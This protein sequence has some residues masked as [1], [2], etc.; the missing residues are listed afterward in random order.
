MYNDNRLLEL[1][2]RQGLLTAKQRSLVEL[3]KRQVRQ[4]LLRRREQRKGGQGKEGAD[5]SQGA[6]DLID[7]ILALRLEHAQTGRPLTEEDLFQAIARESGLPF[8]KL[9]PLDLDIEVVTKT[10]PRSFA[11]RHLILPFKVADGVLSVA[12]CDPD[13]R[14]VLEEVERASQRPI[15]PHITS[16][17]DIRKLLGE[18]HGF[19]SSISAAESHLGGPAVDIAN[20]EQYVRIAS[21]DE[22]AMSDRHIQRAVD[23]LFAY[24]FEQRAS[25]IHLEPKREHC[26]VRLRID[27][28]LHTVYSLPKVVH[29]AIVSRIKAMSRLNIAEK[30]RPQDGRIK[31]DRDGKQSEIRVST[32]PV[33]FGEKVVLR[34]LDPDVLFRDLGDLGFSER[35]L[36]V[37][38]SLIAKPYGIFL[39]TGPTGSGKSTTLYSTLKQ[40][41][42]PELNIV[43]VEDPVEMVCE[44]FNQISVQPQVDVTFSSI[45]RNILRQDP[46]IIMIGEIR[47]GE[48]AA[49][50]VQAALTGHLVFSTLH[51][52]DAVSAITRLLDLGVQP[53]L[54]ASTLIGAMAQRLVRM[55]DRRCKVSRPTP[56]QTITGFGFP[57]D[58]DMVL[59]EG[60]GCRECR[61]TGYFGRCG[62]FEIFAV[63]DKLQSLISAG[64]SEAELRAAAQAE[65]MTTLRQDAWRKV[66]AGVTTLGEAVRVVGTA[67]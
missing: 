50:A 66:A 26:L 11:L 64:A 39:V 29:P 60:K 9:D 61:Q 54:I 30:R 21:S 2:V 67:G 5:I 42:R 45:L 8:V 13:S 53:F 51:T 49:H 22:A 48:T 19:Q 63:S 6:P 47:D 1:L 7:V 10:L 65:G 23:H 31:V 46:D 17:S 62:I 15:R 4:E 38:R 16:R 25:D 3:K 55:I 27:G 12:V 56:A 37:F 57:A 24:A 41:A 59:Y 33:A 32:V 20:L 58:Q 44:E 52:N 35:D 18:F 40:V 36:R 14:E 34:I 43:T 28:R